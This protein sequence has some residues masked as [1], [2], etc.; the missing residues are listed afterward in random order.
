MAYR[1]KLRE[2]A[3][4]LALRASKGWRDL[5]RSLPANTS[6]CLA[7]ACGEELSDSLLEELLAAARTTSDPVIGIQMLALLVEGVPA[8]RPR[9]RALA[10]Q[11][12]Q[13]I[14]PRDLRA[15]SDVLSPEEAIEK[16][17]AP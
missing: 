11:L 2:R 3:R 10:T 16:I 8:L 5:R 1:L 12:A 13:T 9:V 7:V 17:F 4:E 15:R 6:R 14:A